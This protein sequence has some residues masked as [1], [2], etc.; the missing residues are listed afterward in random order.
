M[1]I[2]FLLSLLVVF[3]GKCDAHTVSK[4]DDRLYGLLFLLSSESLNYSTTLPED[5]LICLCNKLGEQALGAKDYVTYFKTGQIAVNSLCLQGDWGLALDKASKMYKEA[6]K[7]NN[8]LGIA[9]AL[10]ALGDTYM[11]TNRYEQAEESFADAFKMLEGIRDDDAKIRL[12]IQYMHV[13][14]HADKIDR[15]PGYMDQ[16]EE[17]IIRLNSRE[18]EN[19]HF[20]YVVTRPCISCR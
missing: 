16:A 9:L 8:R 20:S 4:V 7:Q 19:Y 5:S 3:W 13:C 1:R 17:L 2:L 11:Y 14:L 15:L 12:F 18:K 10:Q 6:R